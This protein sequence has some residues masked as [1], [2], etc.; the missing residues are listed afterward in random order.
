[1][2]W[3]VLRRRRS[4]FPFPF[5]FF[6]EYSDDNDLKFVSCGVKMCPFVIFL[7][8]KHLLMSV[9]SRNASSIGIFVYFLGE[10]FDHVRLSAFA[11]PSSLVQ[12]RRRCVLLCLSKGTRNGCGCMISFLFSSMTI[13]TYT[14]EIYHRH[15]FLFLPMRN[16][17]LCHDSFNV[18]PT[19]N[20]VD[21]YFC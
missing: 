14:V 16:E 4:V 20:F 13:L 5:Q 11:E 10:V 19:K 7:M 8:K 12:E 15:F 1:M 17:T 9:Y 3:G 2:T 21:T 18:F 6:R